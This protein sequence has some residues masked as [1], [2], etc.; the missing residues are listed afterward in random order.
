MNLRRHGE[1]IWTVAQVT[2][3]EMLKDRVLY[4]CGIALVLLLGLA[5]LASGLTHVSPERI[6][7]DFGLTA[8]TV[9][10]VALAILLGGSMLG[11]EIERRTILVALSLPITRNQFLAGKFVGLSVLLAV[12]V[13]ACSIAFA[14]ILILA[15]GAITPVLVGA[16]V[17][18]WGMSL[19]AGAIALFF[20]SATNTALGVSL[21]VGAV[22]V[23][24]NVT[25][26][27]LLSLKS[28]GAL[29][30]VFSA[31]AFVLPN[32]EYFSLGQRVTYGLAVSVPFFVGSL[33]Y[34]VG[35]CAILV[36]GAGTLL[37]RR[38]I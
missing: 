19:V 34:A 32:L 8:V 25:Q 7:L 17:L 5:H 9:S 2:V 24:L 14:V 28:G 10:S 29:G 31:I 3:Q 13:L 38:E 26:I 30:A 1:V 35:W 18:V 22:L 37:Q 36:L 4:N 12:N 21:A 15:G 16:L 6:V 23:G 27:K 20:S 33:L 11:R